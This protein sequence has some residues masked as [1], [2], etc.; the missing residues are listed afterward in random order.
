MDCIACEDILL[1]R[2]FKQYYWDNFEE[3]HDKDFTYFNAGIILW[4]L[5]ELRKD[6]HFTSY[7]EK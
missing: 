3:L 7:V 6:Y 1:N 4:N 5:K 2:M